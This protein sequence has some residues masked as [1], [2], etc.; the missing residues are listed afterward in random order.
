[1]NYTGI[2]SKYSFL[3]AIFS[4][5]ITVIRLFM[6]IY[7]FFFLLYDG[8]T[9]VY[10]LISIIV[11]IIFMDQVDGKI[12]EKTFLNSYETWRDYRRV[13][14]SV[15]DRICIQLFC[16]PLLVLQSDFIVIY[17][18]ILLKELLTSINCIKAY[19]SNIILASNTAGKISSIAI[20]LCVITW[21]LH[22]YFLSYCIVPIILVTGS[23]SY[24][25]YRSS[26]RK[27]FNGI[28]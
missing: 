6:A 28:D 19:R 25:R 7:C 3:W 22:F 2:R 14:D 4:F 8:V 15:C 20:G 5:G 27:Y 10:F 12:F 16:V 17:F 24:I 21:L 11:A 26:Y 9:S 23:I 13:F 1:M 18:A